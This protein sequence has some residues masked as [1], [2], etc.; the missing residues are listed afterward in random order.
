MINLDQVAD[1]MLLRA[2]DPDGA[3]EKREIRRA[4]VDTLTAHSAG[5]WIEHSLRVGEIT[6]V[7]G[8]NSI[9]AR[10]AVKAVETKLGSQQPH[11]VQPALQGRHAGP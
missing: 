7:Y 10:L 1:M 4:A 2:M 11:Q 8:E 9:A 3:A 6:A 5:I